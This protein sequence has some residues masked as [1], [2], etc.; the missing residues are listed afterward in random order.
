M[1]NSGLCR[2]IGR[3]WLA[4]VTLAACSTDPSSGLRINVE[5]QSGELMQ[6]VVSTP[7]SG[8]INREIGVGLASSINVYPAG[9]DGTVVSF[10][11]TPKDGTGP[12]ASGTCTATNE[13]TPG[14]SGDAEDIHGSVVLVL[15]SATTLE[16]ACLG[17]GQPKSGWR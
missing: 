1:R 12:S 5:N 2:K 17:A 7:G 4:L 8:S 11:A 9:G 15:T 16:V 6:L 14:G 13:I 10:S 3:R